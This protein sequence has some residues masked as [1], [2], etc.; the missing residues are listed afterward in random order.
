MSNYRIQISEK[1]R[2]H[3]VIVCKMDINEILVLTEKWQYGKLVEEFSSQ[4]HSEI[5]RVVQLE[6]R[7]QIKGR[8]TH[9]GKVVG[10][11]SCYNYSLGIIFYEGYVWDGRFVCCGKFYSPLAA[12]TASMEME[13]GAGAETEAE[14]NSISLADHGSGNEVENYQNNQRETG[15]WLSYEGSIWNGQ[16]WGTGA[17]S[18]PWNSSH[19]QQWLFDKPATEQTKLNYPWITTTCRTLQEYK[20]IDHSFRRLSFQPFLNQ[21]H[22]IIIQSTCI[23]DLEEF[24]INSLSNLQSL[25]LSYPRYYSIDTSI[26]YMARLIT[27]ESIPSCRIVNCPCLKSIEI[28]DHVF[29]S[30][31]VLEIANVDALEL[32]DIGKGCF[33]SAPTFCLQ[34]GYE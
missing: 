3:E 19:S 11:C 23:T 5:E 33:R 6:N 10:Y 8:L 1:N 9:H 24:E 34:G 21:L 2:L 29:R 25:C 28:G 20:Q 32:I 22:T 4:N 12:E 31:M 18:S 13:A 30:G 14:I 17:V 7:N 16:K 26:E 15:R 27:T